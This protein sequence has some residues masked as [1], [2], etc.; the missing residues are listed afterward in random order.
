MED[1][2]NLCFVPKSLSTNDVL[3]SVYLDGRTVS[4]YDGSGVLAGRLG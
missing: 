1:L 3:L 4:V 2:C